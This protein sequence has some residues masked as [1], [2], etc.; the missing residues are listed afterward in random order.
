MK[1]PADIAQRVEWNNEI[2]NRAAKE[3]IA[4]K[5]A[6]KVK[7]GDVIGVGTGS[8]SYL[9]TLAIAERIKN[10]NLRVQVIPAA[11]EIELTCLELGIPVTTLKDMKPDWGYDGADEVNDQNWLIKGRGGGL[12]KEKMIMSCSEKTYILVDSSKFVKDLGENFAV[13]VECVPES[14]NMVREQLGNMGA[15]SMVLRLAQGKDGPVIT[16]HGNL[17]LDVRFPV[18]DADLD[19]KLKNIVGVVETGL[20]IG[21]NIEVITT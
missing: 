5:I 10:E 3:Q 6:Q 7:D 12:F 20:F 18:I 2:I 13:P 9:S 1:W 11:Y 14:I 4:Q 15:T 21:Y 17:I 19:K 16:E 8:T